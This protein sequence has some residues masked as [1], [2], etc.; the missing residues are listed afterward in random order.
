[1]PPAEVLP[2]G[3]ALT[4]DTWESTGCVPGT[5]RAFNHHTQGQVH[6]L[7]YC[8]MKHCARLLR[9]TACP[10]DGA[11]RHLA[12]LAMCCCDAQ[13][14]TPRWSL[15]GQGAAVPTAP[16]VPPCFR[17]GWHLSQK[18]CA[19]LETSATPETQPS[20]AHAAKSLAQPYSDCT[21]ILPVKRPRNLL[22]KPCKKPLPQLQEEP[23]VNKST[24]RV[25]SRL[26]TQGLFFISNKEMLSDERGQAQTFILL[27]LISQFLSHILN[28]LMAT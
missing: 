10:Q 18:R 23:C 11:C 5:Q 28:C 6:A 7:K 9:D 4:R 2:T 27:L 13:R 17:S 3:R 19:A 26:H 14:C 8:S 12:I 21:F 1:M 25:N 24:R 15:Y 16:E 20:Q 22:R